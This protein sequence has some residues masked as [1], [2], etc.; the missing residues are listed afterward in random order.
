MFLK[1]LCLIF[2]VSA[3]V[4]YVLSPIDLIPE[5]YFGLCGLIDDIICIFIMGLILGSMVIFRWCMWIIIYIYKLFL[6]NNKWK[7]KYKLKNKCEYVN[8]YIFI[9]YT[10]KN[11]IF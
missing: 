10:Y 3:L 11:E 8:K 5:L 2:V 1:N 6:L 4:L 9:L 7:K